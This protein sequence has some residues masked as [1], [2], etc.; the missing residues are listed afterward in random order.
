MRK[1]ENKPDLIKKLIALFVII[2]I[3]I[4]YTGFFPTFTIVVVSTVFGTLLIAY[5]TVMILKDKA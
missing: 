3:L 5:Q 4:L 1:T 2:L